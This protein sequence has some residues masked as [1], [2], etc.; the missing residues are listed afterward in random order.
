MRHCALLFCLFLSVGCEQLVEPKLGSIEPLVVVDGWFTGLS[1]KN[2]VYLSHTTDFGEP[3]ASRPISG[4]LGISLL[5]PGGDTIQAVESP[6][7]PGCY[8]FTLIPSLAG[9]Y[10]LSVPFNGMVLT[11]KD[12]APP[13]IPLDSLSFRFKQDMPT[14]EDG[15]YA[16][17]HFR[18]A[19]NRR[20]YYLWE[21][22][23]S[24]EKKLSTSIN[25]LDDERFDGQNIQYELPVRLER[26]DTV[27]IVLY[28][29]SKEAY[30][31]YTALRDLVNSGSPVL[32]TPNNPPSNLKGGA[33]GFFCASSPSKMTRIVP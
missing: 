15:Y 3:I 29:L 20:N 31:Y 28:S 33:I 26:G 10:Q 13:P 24:S 8:E 30:R 23:I 1:E 2:A 17:I 14:F 32:T 18:D 27:S 16:S 9:E 19:P 4:I 12:I 7:K 21:F 11:A 5:L 25:L 22:W 6:K